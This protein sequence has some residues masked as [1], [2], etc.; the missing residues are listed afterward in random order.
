MCTSG[1]T[2]DSD[3]LAFS[4]ETREPLPGPRLSL[5]LLQHH[6]FLLSL[7]PWAA[8]GSKGHPMRRQHTEGLG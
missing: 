1:G 6:S 8:R 5:R 4:Q 2:D 3:L 7:C